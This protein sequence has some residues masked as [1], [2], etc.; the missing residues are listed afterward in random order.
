MNR[1]ILLKGV[2]TGTGG[3]L[4]APLLQKVAAQASG[5]VTP[6]KRVIFLVFDNGFKDTGALP[7]DTPIASNSLRQFSIRDHRLPFDIEPFAPFK[8]RL[9]LVHGLRGAGAVDHGGYFTAL[10]GVPGPKHSAL[11]QSIDAALAQARPGVFP[12]L[13]LGAQHGGPMT[14]YCSSAWGPGRPIAMMC[15]PEMAYESLFGSVGS[16]RND[17][18][19]RR[20]LLDHVT[21]DLQRVRSEIAG[22]ER[23]LLDVHIESIESLSRRNGQLA[24]QFRNGTLNRHAPTLPTRP[25]LGGV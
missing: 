23:E 15:R 2:A 8:D 20:N 1:R 21:G 11:G 6:P 3:L 24:D 4:L 5:N 25:V 18:A 19:I 16:T 12:I 7:V 13:G 17:F 14:A 9:T 10:S 22:P